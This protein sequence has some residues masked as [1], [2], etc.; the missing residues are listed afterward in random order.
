MCMYTAEAFLTVRRQPS[1]SAQFGNEVGPFLSIEQ[2][3]LSH[4]VPNRARTAVFA[5][6]TVVG[7]LA[8][9]TVSLFAGTLVQ[10]LQKTTVTT[11]GS[12][13]AIVVLYAVIGVL[14]TLFFARLS[15]AT[16]VTSPEEVLSAP[17]PMR[18]F[19][20]IGDSRCLVLKLSSLFALDSFAD[21]FVMQ[22]FAAYWFYIRFGVNPAALGFIFFGANVLAGTS[23]L[24]ASRLASRF[25]LVNTMV[26]SH[27]PS[28]VLL[29]LVPLMPTLSLAV[30]V[31]FLRF[32]IG[33]MDV[34]TRQSYTMAIVRPQ[35]RSATRWPNRCG[36]NNWCCHCSAVC[37]IAICATLTHKLP[38]LYC[39]NTEN[40]LR[41]PAVSRIC[42]HSTS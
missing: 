12:Y 7:A 6:Y 5:W 41:L 4:V 3:A 28:N 17:T 37:G 26:F 9:A 23:A 33:Q 31:L 27:V 29:I 8:T 20:G 34:P 1:F 15:S 16:E 38:V 35:E 21:G 30:L 36:P 10:L 22:T 14:L 13:R 11:A 24:L 2:A 19:L 32:S 18:T 39:R 42:N 25:G 40:R